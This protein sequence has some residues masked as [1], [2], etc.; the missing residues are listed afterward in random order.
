MIKTVILGIVQ[1]ATEFLPVSSSGHLA[2][3]ERFLGY[4]SD[5]LVLETVL[6]LGTLLAL[7]IFFAG[8]IFK[9]LQGAYREVRGGEK[10]KPSILFILYVIVGII[11]AG[12]AGFFLEDAVK[13]AFGNIFF[14]SAFFMASAVIIFL[15]KFAKEGKPLDFKRSLIIGI[16]Q[17]VSLLPGISRSGTT[18]SCGL[19]LGLDRE[20]S[21]DFSFFMAMP[22]I[23]G[24]F[25]KQAI[26]Y[27]IVLNSQIAAG[28]AAAFISGYAALMVLYRLLK[29]GKFYMFSFY[30][31]FV[32]V[33]AFVSGIL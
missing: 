28:F 11:P 10:E 20:R 29:S 22:V 16:A 6:H 13:A 30:L 21:T 4:S 32:S 24:A 33:V 18:I 9:L 1:G 26:D 27:Q 12:L 14:V 7:L 2:L 19:F 3:F 17:V 25:L 5:N 8:K 15:T 31:A 23:L